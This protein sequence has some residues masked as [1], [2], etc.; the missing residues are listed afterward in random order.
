MEALR[1]EKGTWYII[2]MFKIY[3]KILWPKCNNSPLPWK[4]PMVR[5]AY[6]TSGAISSAAG[7][8]C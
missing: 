6:R 8:F 2:A 4:T 1:S 5:G 7:R 3:V